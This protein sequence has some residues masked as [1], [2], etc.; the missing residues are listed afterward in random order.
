MEGVYASAYC[1]I[2]ATS[3]PDSST[4]FQGGLPPPPP[5]HNGDGVFVES[6]AAAGRVA[7][8]STNGADFDGDVN[9]AGLN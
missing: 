7:Y 3:A 9:A 6:A 8:V 2:A 5:P 4:G 1:T